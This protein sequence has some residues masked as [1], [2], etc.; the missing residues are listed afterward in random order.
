VL[1]SVEIERRAQEIAAQQAQ[2]NAFNDACQRTANA[3]KSQ[4]PDFDSRIKELSKLA[5]D[6]DL[7]QQMTYNTFIAAAIETGEA[8]KIL[9]ELGG[10]LDEAARIMSLPPFKMAVELTK[11][12]LGK[13]A[14]ETS[15]APKPITPVGGQR[16]SHSAISPDDP[17]RSDHLTTREWMSRRN[18]QVNKARERA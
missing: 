15:K 7:Q 16:A 4:F 5:G 13:P 2:I 14:T 1:P 9:H 8:P 17:D 6:G 10:N 12:A 18:E 11:M 3:G